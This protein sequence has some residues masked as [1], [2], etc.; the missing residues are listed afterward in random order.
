MKRFIVQRRPTNVDQLITA[1]EAYFADLRQNVD[2]LGRAMDGVVPRLKAC[3]A[4]N[5]ANG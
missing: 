5:G 3:I 1:A 4:L 2:K